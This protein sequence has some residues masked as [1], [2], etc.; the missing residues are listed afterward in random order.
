MGC[1]ALYFVASVVGLSFL[2]FEWW[3]CRNAHTL[4]PVVI[5]II[6][7]PISACLPCRA[8][9]LPVCCLPAH[10]LAVMGGIHTH[11]HVHARAHKHS[12]TLC[13]HAP[14]RP[15]LPPCGLC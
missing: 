7:C 13:A 9:G 3:R 5:G 11:T 4:R 1:L 12:D 2:F 10:K 14:L 8:K 15:D 6:V